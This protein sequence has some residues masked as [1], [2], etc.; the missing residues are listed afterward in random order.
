[1]SSTPTPEPPAFC[2]EESPFAAAGA[3]LALAIKTNNHDGQSDQDLTPRALY[4]PTTPTGM[5]KQW[6]TQLDEAY[7]T[8]KALRSDLEGLRR[9]HHVAL[10]ELGAQE[11]RVAE[12]E[13]DM[14]SARS[15]LAEQATMLANIDAI[16]RQRIA[17]AMQPVVDASQVVEDEDARLQEQLH[18]MICSSDSTSFMLY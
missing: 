17:D 13:A 14:S 7:A 10:E 5:R 3:E 11:D 15:V 16:V 9:V 6:T 12:L 2:H 1:M 4:S 8:I 18:V